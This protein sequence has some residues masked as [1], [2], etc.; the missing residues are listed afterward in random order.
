MKRLPETILTIFVIGLIT[1]CSLAQTAQ[2][3]ATPSPT[4][5]ATPSTS[6]TELVMEPVQPVT[7][8]PIGT[9]GYPWWNDSV[10]YEI[11]VR[12]FYD[13]DGDGI[14]DFNGIREKLDYLN[15]GDASTTED[16]GITG[17]WLMPIFPSPS[18]HGYD[19]T[20]YYGV[21]PE[22]GTMDDFKALL[23]EAHERGIRVIIDLVL[24]HTSSQH[25][26][27]VEGRSVASP[28]HDWY[29]WSNF[30]PGYTGS[31]GQQVWY[32]LDGRY[33]YSSFTAGMPDLNYTNPEVTTEMKN[34]TRFWLEEVGVD[35]FRL[36]AAKHLIEEGTIQAN[37][38]STHEWWEGFRPFYKEIAPQAMIVGEI[39][40]DTRITEK[41]L[42][43]D[44]LDLAFEFYLANDLVLAAREENA[45]IAGERLE[46]VLEIL[47]G[48][49][50]APFLTNHDQNRVMTQLFDNYDKARVAASMLLT[51]PG[52]PFIY[53]GEEI[54]MQGEKPDEMIRRP[55]QW[56]KFRNAGFTSGEPWERLGPDWTKDNVVMEGYDKNSL[57]AHY[58]ALIAARNQHAALRVGITGIVTTNNDALY[59]ILRVSEDEAVLVLVNLSGEP[60][61]DYL[62]SVDES[63]LAEGTYTLLT[64]LGEGEFTPMTVTTGGRFAFYVPLEEIPPFA[65]YIMQLHLDTP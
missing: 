30:N 17:V 65:T 64:I 48:M 59:S 3:T 29:I 58:R 19:V 57:L 27:F 45:E 10:F 2:P 20:D 6:P 9:D 22:Y 34:V 49:Q 61:S 12:S 47:P 62:L 43:G 13:S 4:E 54:G 39:W 36:D 23:A 28:Y 25:P 14:G 35:G 46:N 37:S 63:A 38:E 7:G 16:L 56:S 1:S 11:F 21:N 42:E 60:I 53:Y 26:W 32:P 24:N 8:M 15:D 52:V 5:T 31:W 41:Y 50:F 51:A 40:D 44:E 18:Y 55:M 33:Y